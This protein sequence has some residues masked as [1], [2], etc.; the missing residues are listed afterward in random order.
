VTDLKTMAAILLAL[1]L[2]VAPT[3]SFA[4]ATA[5]GASPLSV[6]PLDVNTCPDTH[7]IKGN[8]AGRQAARPVDPIY[9]VPGSRYYLA[10]D[11][12]ECFATAEDAEA[13]GYRAPLR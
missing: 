6:R 2:L 3:P 7:P 12:E 8:K 5:P 10:T 11:P 4:Q 1:T 9:H 13:A